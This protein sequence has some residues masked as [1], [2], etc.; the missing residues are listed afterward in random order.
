MGINYGKM[1]AILWKAVQETL[2]TVEHL[3]SSVFELQEELEELKKRKANAK[4]KAK[5]EK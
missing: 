4:S 3:Q 2:N 1:S 5:A